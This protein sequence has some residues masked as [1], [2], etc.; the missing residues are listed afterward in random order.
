MSTFKPIVRRSS[1]MWRSLSQCALAWSRHSR[2][3]PRLTLKLEHLEDRTALSSFNLA[4]TSPADAGPGTLRSA[5]S[6]ADAGSARHEYNIE[7]KVSGTIA[8]ESALPNLSNRVNISGPGASRLTVHRGRNATSDFGIFVVDPGVAVR[9]TGMTIAGGFAIVGSG[10]GI[11][12]NGTLTV[13]HTTVS[14]NTAYDGGGIYNGNTGTLTLSHTTIFGNT[15]QD[16]GGIKND[17]TITASHSTISGNTAQEG[18]GIVNN[19]TLVVSHSTMLGNQ[20]GADSPGGGIENNGTLTLSHTTISRNSATNGGGIDNTGTL[21]A[22]HT[23]MFENSATN[24]GGIDNTGMLTA[25]QITI[26]GNGFVASL[27]GA[28]DNTGTLTVSHATITNNVATI[29]SG[30][31]NSGGGQAEIDY[32]TITEPGAAAALVN[33]TTGIANIGSTVHLETTVVNGVLYNDEYYS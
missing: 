19:G 7:I 31:Y 33:N 20:A 1:A 18:G 21:T 24:G 27:G 10:G 5:I 9:I 17:G 11:D 15:A 3:R 22:S 29:V 8:L 32:S 6:E 30:V 25:N 16:G 26:S 4:V 2:R 13:S 14:G 28:I 12:N 23:T